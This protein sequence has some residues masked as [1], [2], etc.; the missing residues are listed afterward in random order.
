MVCSRA[1]V[2]V[3]L[4]FAGVAGADVVITEFM[5]SNDSTLLDG[6]GASSDWVELHNSGSNAV[7]LAGWYLSDDP[8]ELDKWAFPSTNIAAGG[9]IVV[10][11]SGTDG[12]AYVDPAGY[13][14][15]TFRL[16]RNDDGQGECVALVQPDGV[17][18]AHGFMEYPEQSEDVSYGL[19]FDLAGIRLVAAREDA[20]AH[21]PAGTVS[22][23]ADAGFDD[24][25]WMNGQTAVG[26]EHE[27][28][29]QTAIHLD[30]GAMRNNNPSVYVRVPFEV[31]DPARFDQLVLRMQYDDGFVAYLNGQELTRANA[32]TSTAWNSRAT[33]SHEAVLGQFEDFD[34]SAAVGALAAGTNVLAFQG[35]NERVNSS[36][37]LILPELVGIDVGAPRADQVMFFTSPT[38]G[39]GNVSGIDGF[40]ADTTFTVDRGFYSN[41]FDV[42]IATDTVG[43]QIY[44]TLDGRDPTPATGTLYTNAVSIGATTVLRARAVK[45]GHVPSDADTQTYI[46][47]DDVVTQSPNGEP[48][49]PGWPGS[50]VKGQRFDYGMDTNVTQDA[51]Y[52]GLIDD[53][54]LAIPSVSLVTDLANL[55]DPATGIYV[56]ARM[57]GED[58][59]RETSVELINPDGTDGF[60][61]NAG[62]RIRGNMSTSPDN[63]KHSLRLFF[64]TEYGDN[65]LEYALF[66][67]EGVDAFRKIDLRTAQN[68][69]WNLTRGDECTFVREVFSR[70]L[71]G[72]MGEPYTRSRYYHVYLNGHYWGLYQT[73]ERA[74]AHYGESY[75]GGD[76]DDYD[77]MKVQMG[78]G[79]VA[80]DGNGDAYRELWQAAANGFAAD[81]DYCAVQGLDAAGVRDPAQR[82][83]LDVDNLVDYMIAVYYV[84][85]RDG[86][87]SAIGKNRIANNYYAIFNRAG[88]DGFQFFRHDAEN[89]LLDVNED[90][91]GPWEDPNLALESQFSPQWLHQRLCANTNYVRRF[92]DRVQRHC[93]NGGLLTEE[94][95]QARF[96][97]RVAEVELA[98][99]AESA[100]WGD[101]RIEPPRTK[102]D[103][104]LPELA[105]VTNDYFP[106]RREILLEQLL[107]QGWYPAVD[108]PVFSRHGGSFGAGFTLGMSGTNEVYYTLDGSDPIDSGT[109]YV[110]PVACTRTVRVRARALAGGA[111]SALTE[112]VFVPESPVATLRVT[113]LMYHPAGS[114]ET[115][116][117]ESDFEFIEIQN[118]GSATTGL[119]GVEFVE[120]I[121]FDFTD[122]GIES[123]GPG[124]F[125]VLVGNL[126]AFTNRYPEGA[127]MCIGGEY[128]GRFFLPGA[129]ANEG[130][131]IEL[132]DGLGRT[133]QRFGYDDGW[134]PVTDGEGFSLTVLDAGA[135]TNA[136]NAADGWRAS[137]YAGGTPGDASEEFWSPG[138]IV[139]NEVLTHQ[140]QDDPGDWIELYNASSETISLNGW[141]VSDDEDNPAKV[142]LSNVT[143]VLPGGYVVLTE[144][145][146]FGTNAA[147]TNGFAL[148]ELGEGVYLSS[149]TNGVLTGYRD[150][151]ELGASEL[152]VTFGRYVRSDAVVDVT[153]LS[154]TSSGMSN[155]Y[156][157]VGPVVVSEIMYHPADSNAFEFVELYNSAATDVPLYDPAV[158]T[159]TWHLDGAVSFVFPTNIVIPA[160]GCVL[161]IP[162]NEAAFT[163]VY[164]VAEGVRVV[165]PYSGKLSNGGETLELDRPGDPEPLTGETPYILVERVEYDDANPWP[166]A[167]DGQGASLERMDVAGY[168]NDPIGWAA[169]LAGP[170]PGVVADADADG[171]P[172][173]WE[174]LHFGGTD[175]VDGGADDDRDGDGMC[176]LAEWLAGTVPTNAG[177]A[178][179]LQSAEAGGDGELIVSW[180]SVSNRFY[181][182]RRST[183]LVTGFDATEAEGLPATPPVNT[184]TSGIP[185]NP[186][187]AFY[188]VEVE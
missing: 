3:C 1:F 161:V 146:H 51:R 135:E 65:T 13:L 4:S 133:I 25:G 94:V 39:A 79:V 173:A 41:A 76:D 180:S 148:S 86:P 23:W 71:Q 134:Y 117:L 139:I 165:G 74:D 61:I 131:E 122:C 105:A 149:G 64:R 50:P 128:G 99:I 47:V 103:D 45:A 183:N 38:P 100:R 112:A 158:P 127:G 115:N 116:Y 119:A 142:V 42:V 157:L 22:G 92:G 12:A 93:F 155:D 178:L 172:D 27:Q 14:H 26:Y 56:N 184:H 143:A 130:E 6:N 160:G 91:T 59:E 123:L 102:D 163:G 66:G 21:I 111:W 141:Y 58:W 137:A 175:A 48:P 176:N 109:L 52:A 16:S 138:D 125:L 113:E 154:A 97:A 54:L 60:Q 8:E 108:A 164:A 140:D 87:I 84:G 114:T 110:E 120:G 152:D 129:L 29:Y 147:G 44:Y 17:T 70:D 34:V 145:S 77:V 2:V 159:N 170:T 167:A 118:T 15:A 144:A 85:D 40:V 174:T 30:V 153:A 43:A 89:T 162:T 36:D 20:R 150:S 72:E 177:S 49:G 37:L 73:Q 9:Y 136:W 121:S 107:A 186:R 90:R 46:F 53:A 75:L 32:P 28:G 106:Y 124:E 95:C 57:E 168:G 98:I 182:I 83:L 24:S 169:C 81:A 33:L 31:S 185:D 179:V 101:A 187:G 151:V 7:D 80:T 88:E 35:L 10:F 132:V 181:A 82:V 104:W 11:A 19:P 96:A 171:L 156:P 67:D 126:E 166:V 69:S 63:P 55:F 62:L 5:A 188:R 18:V 78:P 68:T